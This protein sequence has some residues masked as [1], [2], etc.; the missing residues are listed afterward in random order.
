MLSEAKREV[1]VQKKLSQRLHWFF[2]KIIFSRKVVPQL[3]AHQLGTIQ[4]SFA[5]VKVNL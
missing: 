5:Q 2:L 4:Q 3:T 1:G